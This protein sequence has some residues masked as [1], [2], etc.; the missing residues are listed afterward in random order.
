MHELSLARSILRQVDELCN[1]YSDQLISAVEL[2][3]GLMSGVDAD[4][5]A[6]SL[7]QEQ[8]DRKQPWVF[9]INLVPVTAHC[10]NCQKEFQIDSYAFICVFCGSTRV[11]VSG[12]DCVRIMSV[13]LEDLES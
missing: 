11:D 4:L 2:E 9:V 10:L 1:E 5:L 13:T 8:M 7:E 12:G 6:T 3:V